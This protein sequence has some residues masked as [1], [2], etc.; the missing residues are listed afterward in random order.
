[1]DF[2]E[3]QKI[4]LNDALSAFGKRIFLPQGIFYWAGMAK[5]KASINGTIGTAKGNELLELI[6]DG[7]D[8]RVTFYLKN[9]E[10]LI[11]S[12]LD[13]SVISGYAPIGGVP[14]LR[15]K[16]KEWIL[17][18]TGL[19]GVKNIE[20]LVTLPIVTCGLTNGLF[21]TL[22]YFINE[23]E[24]VLCSNKYWGN[25]GTIINLNIGGKIDTF[26]LFKD[27][28][29]DTE[30][31]IAK[32]KEIGKKEKKV[33]LLLNFPNNPTGYV[34][35]FDKLKEIAISLTDV[36]SE[37][38]VPVIVVCDDAYEG[39]VYDPNAEKRS[40]FTFLVDKSPYLIPIKLDGASKELLFYGGRVGFITIGL[41]SEWDADLEKLAKELDNKISGGIRS[42]ISNS[43]HISQ[44][45][46]LKMMDE[47]D[48]SMKNR[49]KV[50]KILE[51][52]W[53]V[54]NELSAAL[55][56]PEKGIVF[57]PFQGGFFAFLNLPESLP[58][59]D[60]AKKL[61]DEQ[62]L[63]V[64]PIQKPGVNGIRIAYCSMLKNEIK[65]ALEKISKM[66][67]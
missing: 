12:E 46:V 48:D 15:K 2:P 5:E 55:N 25:Y 62:K 40:L 4:P 63:G 20:S 21:V 19:K 24:T 66:L 33:V 49:E 52:R 41:S 10:S 16:W 13:A 67:K 36:A 57:D 8:K 37:I 51:E 18:K 34:P 26:N 31:M 54:F 47:R 64:I 11:S 61:I 58:A 28:I 30:S 65:E 22:R 3:L 7:S 43:S 6:K 9:I 42:T 23:G 14:E 50:I 32:V 39:Y 60:F 59:S 56:D 38:K 29:F 1:M 35:T 27:G 45:L 44:R 17:E 53:K